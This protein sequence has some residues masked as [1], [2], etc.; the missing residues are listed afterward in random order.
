MRKENL[1]AEVEKL[2]QENSKSIG[3]GVENKEIM[4]MFPKALWQLDYNTGKNVYTFTS[5]N[6]INYTLAGIDAYLWDEATGENSIGDI[7][8]KSK[9]E[10]GIVDFDHVLSFYKEMDK[11]LAIILYTI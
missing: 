6:G 8:E 7:Y 10:Y 4:Q 11:Q 2:K 5:L 9:I 1:A 3:F